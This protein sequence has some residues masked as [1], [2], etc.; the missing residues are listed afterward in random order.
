MPRLVFEH[1]LRG[2]LEPRRQLDLAAAEARPVWTS[3][4]AAVGAQQ[5]RPTSRGRASTSCSRPA[6]DAGAPAGLRC[7]VMPSASPAR[8]DS[9]D[10]PG[11]CS[12]NCR[13]SACCALTGG[14]LR[15]LTGRACA[16]ARRLAAELAGETTRQHV[17]R[18]LGAL[19]SADR[20]VAAAGECEC[21][22]GPCGR[23]PAARGARLAEREVQRLELRAARAAD[24]SR[25]G[26]EHGL[27]VSRRQLG[28]RCALAATSPRA[29]PA[30]ASA[31]V[32]RTCRARRPLA[33]RGAR[34]RRP[35]SVFAV[36]RARVMPSAAIAADGQRNA[37]RGMRRSTPNAR[38][39]SSG[40]VVRG[41]GASSLA[42]GYAVT[43]LPVRRSC[44]IASACTNVRS[45]APAIAES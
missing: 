39:A 31:R 38:V 28:S 45:T 30:R 44:S 22:C 8:D 9:A 24:K 33:P 14:A 26:R 2:L 16:T 32:R 41:C 11:R 23:R 25:R 20:L 27:L 3:S 36:G 12:T 21:A 18:D 35:T 19:A 13:S 43:A 10:R 37:P 7:D 17:P 15:D 1:L 29:A 4:G 42:V 5:R 34:A 6:L 40:A